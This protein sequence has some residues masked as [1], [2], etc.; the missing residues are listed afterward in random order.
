VRDSC[1]QCAI[2]QPRLRSWTSCRDFLATVSHFSLSICPDDLEIHGP[3]EIFCCQLF[4]RLSLKNGKEHGEVK[5]NGK[6]INT[7]YLP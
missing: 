7:V 6:S 1:H 4:V 3:R 5:K 2:E